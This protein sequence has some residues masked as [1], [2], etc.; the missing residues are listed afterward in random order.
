MMDI[1]PGLLLATTNVQPPP[2]R[3]A[4]SLA[5]GIELESCC[6]PK[7][8]S[9]VLDYGKSEGIGCNV[10][11]STVSVSKNRF[12]QQ[13]APASRWA[14]LGGPGQHRACSVPPSHCRSSFPERRFF[15][16]PHRPTN[17]VSES[18]LKCPK[19]V[20]IIIPMP[21]PMPMPIRFMQPEPE[22]CTPPKNDPR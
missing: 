19:F 1:R 5:I 9:T 22:L 14:L 3:R 10:N 11:A 8:N 21:M 15:A 20:T 16:E 17:S 4:R 12:V 6:S 13:P 2:C 7:S 18:S